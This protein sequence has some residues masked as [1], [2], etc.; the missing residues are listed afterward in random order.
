VE[1]ADAAPQLVREV[2]TLHEGGGRLDWH[3]GLDLIAFDM[4]GEDGQ[5]DVFAMRGDGS[6]TRNV[7][8][9]NPDLPRRHV[10]QPAWHPSGN[11]LVVQAE[12]SDHP[13][14]RLERVVEPGA[15][16]YNDLW[17]VELGS[18]RAH[19]LRVVP[20]ERG[21]GVLHAHFDEEGRRLAWSEMHAPGRL[22]GRRN[23]LGQWKLMVADFSFEGGRPRLSNVRSYEP[24][25]PGFYENH[26]F[27]PD[28]TK[29]LFTSNFEA[30]SR[31]ESHIYTL[32]LAS[33]RLTRLTEEDTW[34]EHAAYSPDGRSIVWMAR[35][36]HGRGTDYWLMDSDGSNKRRLT[37]FNEPGHPHFTGQETV[38]ADLAWGP[39]DD[40][41][42]IY[43]RLG[44]GLENKN[45]PRR[46]VLL[47]LDGAA[48]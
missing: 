35:N 32:E 18:P 33:S 13:A 10:G 22:R 40:R 26:G 48:R 37:W 29:L 4:L 28:G 5:Y 31:L 36:G 15:G 12:K 30:R 47:V 19:P 45:S 42:A 3:H 9:A 27:S 43:Q 38:V 41:L 11:Y 2:R 14:T 34:N 1:R 25:G 17:L 8:G 44:G 16:V 46:I 21:A 6:A 23:L 7:T 24:G 39:G 20:N